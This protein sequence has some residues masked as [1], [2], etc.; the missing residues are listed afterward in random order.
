MQQSKP[1]GG[2]SHSRH[3]IACHALRMNTPWP[4]DHVQ[5]R[6]TRSLTP[7]ARNARQHSDHQ[8]EQIVASIRTWGWA[9]PILIDEQ[10]EI[11][12]GHGR[13]LAADRLGIL[14]VPVMTARGWTDAH[15]RVYLIAGNKLTE[16]ASRDYD[17]LRQELEQLAS[18]G[19][20]ASHAGYDAD[21]LA[22][23]LDARPHGHTDP[24]EAPA[25]PQQPTTR[26]GDLFLLGRH[27]LICGDATDANTVARLFAN[28]APNLMV[29][30]VLDIVGEQYG[31]GDSDC[32]GSNVPILRIGITDFTR[33]VETRNPCV[34]EPRANEGKCVS[35]D[36]L[37]RAGRQVA[38]PFFFNQCS[39]SSFER[40][41]QDHLP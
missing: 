41:V 26:Q 22:A 16:N 25:K 29:T 23:L 6:A 40:V 18:Y 19:F 32:G 30:E 14:Q 11:I 34:R 38:Q 12:A 21:E 36:T 1:F 27:R 3:R 20:D 9:I 10:G 39:P 35:L 4:A 15:K 28:D 31:W 17:L 8:I 13:V 24:D 2:D 37:T 5:R 33:D 7:S